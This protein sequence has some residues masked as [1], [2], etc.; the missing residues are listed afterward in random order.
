[1]ARVYV[2][3]YAR[4][5]R[6]AAGY[7]APM[8]VDE[9]A[10]V[11]QVL[12]IGTNSVQSLT[13]NPLTK[14]V[15]IIAE[16]S[17]SVA[18]GTNPTATVDDLRLPRD[19][20]ELFSI[21][22]EKGY[23]VAVIYNPGQPLVWWNDWNLVRDFTPLA[24]VGVP[25][26]NTLVGNLVKD[27]FAVGDAI[28]YQSQEALHE[29][30]EGTPLHVHMHWAL[31]AANNATVRGVKFE[32]EWTWANPIEHGSGVTAFSSSSTQ[33]AEFVIAANEPDRTH[34]VS[35]I[36]IIPGDGFAIGSQII[37]RLKRIAAA[38]TA[39][40]ADP[41]VISF[42]IHYLADTDGSTSITSK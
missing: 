7:L 1:M 23:K 30:Q 34:H 9:P 26:R 4:Q 24:G 2:T 13:F 35:S 22:F 39:P 36:Y 10:L 6:D 40:A 31:G 41:F 29:W 25:P 28:Q 20:S 42:G 38:G 17:V 3:E 14:F 33:S 19:V 11:T 18:F 27:Q 12:D 37:L 8:T 21:P 15:R 16:D 5:G 32:I